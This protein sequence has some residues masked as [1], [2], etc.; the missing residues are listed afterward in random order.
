M[1]SC[2]IINQDIFIQ[3]DEKRGIFFNVLHVCFLLYFLFLQT[4]HPEFAL[5]ES[6]VRRRY[7]EFVW[8]KQ[9][10][11]LNDVMMV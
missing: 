3:E 1:P 6:I 5:K 7:S 11:G 4:N 8:L 10:F 2:F 9:R